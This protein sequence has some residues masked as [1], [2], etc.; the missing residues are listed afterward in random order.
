MHDRLQKANKGKCTRHVLG[1]RK[2][3]KKGIA[4]NVATVTVLTPNRQ[5]AVKGK[6]E[7]YLVEQSDTVPHMN[8]TCALRCTLCQICVHTFVCTCVDFGLH[9]TICKHIHL[10]VSALKPVISCAPEVLTP[11]NTAS[12]PAEVCEPDFAVDTVDVVVEEEVT[13]S[14][15]QQV[16]ETD[17]IMQNLRDM[18]P[19]ANIQHYID[20]AEQQMSLLRAG[21]SDSVEIAAAVCQQLTRTVALMTA[22]RNKPQLPQLPPGCERRTRHCRVSRSSRRHTSHR[23]CDCNSTAAAAAADGAWSVSLSVWTSSSSSSKSDVNASMCTV[24]AQTQ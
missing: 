4:M 14:N 21:I 9:C 13:A 6:T 23:S 3:H 12:Y 15:G 24:C 2:R 7:T 19:T 8:T 11:Q 18:K 5:Y 17:V 22:L 16:D 20:V 10:V 1:I